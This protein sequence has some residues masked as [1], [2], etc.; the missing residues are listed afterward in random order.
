MLKERILTALVLLALVLA[1]IFKLPENY[2]AL[3]MGLAMMAAC[4]EWAN[5]AGV[6]DNLWRGVYCVAVAV[7]MILLYLFPQY[8][9]NL[10]VIVWW[11]LALAL[12]VTY[13]ASAEL[14]SGKKSLTAMEKKIL[15][16]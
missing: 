14:W 3:F 1:A 6:T 10:V 9:L 5:L 13:P 4:W 8:W 7:L 15:Q 2:F 12:V 11:A 16:S